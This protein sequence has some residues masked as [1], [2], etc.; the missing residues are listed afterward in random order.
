MWAKNIVCLK[1]MDRTGLNGQ[2]TG[3]D[4][5]CVM[6]I[7]GRHQVYSLGGRAG[8]HDTGDEAGTR[9]VCASLGWF[10]GH[11]DLNPL[12]LHSLPPLF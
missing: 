7:R 1:L 2:R 4:K 8:P 12:A 5:Y 6:A 3:Y 9:T 11:S 10:T